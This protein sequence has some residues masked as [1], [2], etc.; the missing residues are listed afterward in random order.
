MCKKKKEFYISAYYI[1]AKE[2]GVKNA[3]PEFRT[4][5]LSNGKCEIVKLEM[6][7]GFISYFFWVEIH[8]L[9]EK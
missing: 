5:K 6:T 3:K 7:N 9:E 4:V 2:C 8:N 1:A